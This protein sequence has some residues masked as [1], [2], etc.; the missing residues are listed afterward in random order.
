V[1]AA[2]AAAESLAA[3]RDAALAQWRKEVE[4]ARYQAN[5]AERRYMAVDPDNRLVARGL[6]ADWEAKLAALTIAEAELALKEAARPAGLGP[7]ERA[8]L[9]AMGGDLGQV[10]QAPTTTDRDRKELLRTLVEE[11]VVDVDREAAEAR[12]TLR[13][14]GGATSELRVALKR[15]QPTVRTDEGTIGLVRRLAQHHPDATIAGILNRQ[16]RLSARGQRFTGPTVASLRKYWGDPLLPEAR[17]ASRRRTGPPLPSRQGARCGAFHS[18]PLGKR[19]VHRR[20]PGHSR[21]TMAGQDDRGT[22]SA[23]R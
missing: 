12:L 22:E 1:E 4:R 6:E 15:K 13:W 7:D 16:G 8:A 9:L 14:R 21:G 5:L 11:V 19:G 23:V 20:R 17:S 2:L 3:D 10:W 18:L